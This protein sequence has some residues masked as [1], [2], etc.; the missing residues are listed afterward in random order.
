MN[1][2]KLKS[3]AEDTITHKKIV[4]DNCL[5]MFEYL[6]DN[7]QLELGIELLRR[8]AKH[9][10]SKFE[11]GEFESL[12]EILESRDCFTNANSVLSDYEIKAIERHWKENRHHPEYFSSERNMSELDIIEMVCDW[13][14]RSIQYKTDFIP[15]VEERQRKRFKF[16]NEKFKVI[17]YYCNLI[18]K[19]YN[20]RNVENGNIQ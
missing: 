1:I 15:F 6:A 7:G 16:S 4:M 11:S 14:A 10:N 5:L 12:A 2:D 19:L 18:Q 20:E 8:G 17:L 9:D 13:F 3:M